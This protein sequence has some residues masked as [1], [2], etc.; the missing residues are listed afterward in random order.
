MT[1]AALLPATIP[2]VFKAILV[3]LALPTLD[4]PSGKWRLAQYRD[5]R[6]TE[7]PGTLRR[8]LYGEAV[9]TARLRAALKYRQVSFYRQ[10]S[11]ALQGYEPFLHMILALPQLFRT[12]GYRGWVLLFDEGEAIIQVPRLYV[13]GLSSPAPCTHQNPRHQACTLCSPSPDFPAAHAEDTTGRPS[14]TDA[15]SLA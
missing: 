11:L 7:F 14:S 2:H 3:A 12:M 9:P 10:A 1:L 8:A 6:P 4:I 13:L 15:P 5:F